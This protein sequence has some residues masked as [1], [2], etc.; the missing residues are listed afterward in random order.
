MSEGQREALS[1]MSEVMGLSPEV[2]L[3]QLMAHLGF[4]GEVHVGKGL[5]D[6]EDDELI[7]V[8]YRHCAELKARSEGTT[9]SALPPTGS[10]TSVSGSSMLPKAAPL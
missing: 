5:G 9:N 1:V 10:A 7:A 4:L 3:G 2:R 8:L 6:I